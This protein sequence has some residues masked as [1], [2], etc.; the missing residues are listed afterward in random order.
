MLL[1]L[2]PMPIERF[3]HHA[4]SKHLVAEISDLGVNPIQRL[5]DDA[6]DEG[7]SVY[8]KRTGSTTVWAVERTVRKEDEIVEWILRPLDISC[9]L[10]PGVQDYVMHILND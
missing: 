8:N 10:Y 3:S 6:C 7:L 4:Q 9:G 2:H 5:Y 1:L